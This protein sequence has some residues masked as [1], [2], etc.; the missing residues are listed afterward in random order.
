[1]FH[2]RLFKSHSRLGDFLP[3]DAVTFSNMTKFSNHCPV[4]SEWGAA[5]E[6]PCS[7]EHVQGSS[8]WV[9]PGSL[10][11]HGLPQSSALGLG[12]P[13]VNPCPGVCVE[14]DPISAGSWCGCSCPLKCSGVAALKAC[15]LLLRVRRCR[16]CPSGYRALSTAKNL[17]HWWVLWAASQ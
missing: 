10:Q 3:H 9:R 11:L 13:G 6:V 16:L 4:L 8:V 1:M 15:L 17:G 2:Q 14:W 7:L 5:E 12:D